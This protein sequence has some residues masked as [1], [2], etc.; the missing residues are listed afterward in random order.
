MPAWVFQGNKEH[1]QEL[2]F[3]SGQAR[4]FLCS[5]LKLHLGCAELWD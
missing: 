4:T 2:L 3:Y 5:G 1:F